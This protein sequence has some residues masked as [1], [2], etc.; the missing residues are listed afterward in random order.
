WSPAIGLSNS[1]IA[2]PIV[3]AGAIGD[4]VQYEVTTSTI[5][6]CKGFG[7]V[8]VKVYKGP[9]IYMPT[10]FTPNNDGKNDKFTPF[11]V[12]IKNLN[13]F[14]VYNRWGQMVFSTNRL[15]EGWDG[16]INGLEQGTGT[17]VWMVEGVTL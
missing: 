16:R 12:G 2:N 13:Y 15:Y 17:Y 6:G 3:T 1:F 4:V 8:T 10:G 11:P 5:A 14:R 9:D 7:Y